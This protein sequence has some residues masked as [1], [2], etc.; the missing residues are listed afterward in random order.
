MGAMK[1]TTCPHDAAWPVHKSCW[2]LLKRNRVVGAALE[3]SP[4]EA[5]VLPVDTPW[6]DFGAHRCPHA[7]L[8]TVG[9]WEPSAGAAPPMAN[10]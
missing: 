2:L 7:N 6:G 4:N 1:R 9:H 3:V 5:F 10:G 8:N